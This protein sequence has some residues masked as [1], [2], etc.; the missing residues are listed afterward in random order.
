MKPGKL[1]FKTGF[2]YGVMVFPYVA[3]LTSAYVPIGMNYLSRSNFVLSVD[4]GPQYWYGERD[5][6]IGFSVKV[7]KAF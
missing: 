7:G 4:A 1:G 5:Y 6:L 3:V 2:T